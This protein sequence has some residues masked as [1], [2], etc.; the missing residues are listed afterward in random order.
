M[1]IRTDI[2]IREYEPEDYPVLKDWWQRHDAERLHEDMIPKS[3]VIVEDKNGPAGFAG[4][5]L[6]NCNQV[7]FCLGL[8]VR[9]GLNVSESQA[10]HETLQDGMDII[11]RSGG[12][13][14][15]L[16]TVTGKGMARGAQ[17]MG[18]LVMSKPA[19]HIARIVKPETD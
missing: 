14:V 3:S 11:M 4:L 16:G 2:R 5:L 18:F 12:H 15:L 10:I 9:P 6:S 7:A 17:R 13:T 1:E 8:V 19:F